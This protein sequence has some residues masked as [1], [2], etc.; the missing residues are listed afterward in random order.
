MGPPLRRPRW[1]LPIVALSLIATIFSGAM[2]LTL[3]AADMTESSLG[4]AWRNGALDR[5]L[6]DTRAGLVWW[7]RLAFATALILNVGALAIFDKHTKQRWLIAAGLGLAGAVLISAAWLGHAGA[8]PSALRA[9][10]LAIHI[11]HI[12]AAAIWLGGLL[13]FVLLLFQANRSAA[14]T[15]FAIAHHIGI[16]FGNLAQLAVGALLLSGIVNTALVVGS[17]WDFVTGAFAALLATKVG[18]LLVML[19]LAAENRRRLVPKLASN[20]SASAARLRRNVIGEL[21]LGGLIL[22]VVGALGITSPTGG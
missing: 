10:H 6:F 17:D 8:D 3:Q 14:T 15:G 11:T 21:A 4:E 20:G 19:V 7:I 18:L 16:R 22:V 9:L 13:P 2:W 12:L 5:L 1:L